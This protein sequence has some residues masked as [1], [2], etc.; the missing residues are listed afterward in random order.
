MHADSI[1]INQ[2]TNLA[3]P[4]ET[5]LPC[6]LARRSRQPDSDSLTAQ[7]KRCSTRSRSRATRSPLSTRA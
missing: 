4:S 6:S 3:R 1:S 7:T 5:H 2:S